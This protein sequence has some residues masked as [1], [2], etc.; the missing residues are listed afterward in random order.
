ML[1]IDAASRSFAIAVAFVGVI[2]VSTFPANAEGAGSSLAP[3]REVEVP[4][5]DATEMSA[6]A[7]DVTAAAASGGTLIVAYFGNNREALALIWDATRDALAQGKPVKMMVMA[8]PFE[9][10]IVNGYEIRSAE[11]VRIYADGITTTVIEDPDAS[12][13]KDV[14]RA[15]DHGY[16]LMSNYKSAHDQ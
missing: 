2:L 3:A 8:A 7:A 4:V 1:R 15:L 10:K 16:V 13:G 6:N 11:Q 5:F 12:I 14:S 9:D